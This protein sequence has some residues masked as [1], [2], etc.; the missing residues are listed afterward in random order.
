[1]GKENLIFWW[2]FEI[3]KIIYT[4]ELISW[5]NFHDVGMLFF[6]LNPLSHIKITCE[7]INLWAFDVDACDILCVWCIISIL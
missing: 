5:G 1:M 4:H 7:N 6:Y 2:Y 3:H